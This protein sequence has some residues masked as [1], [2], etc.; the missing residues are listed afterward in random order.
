MPEYKSSIARR[1]LKRTSGRRLAYASA[2]LFVVGLQYVRSVAGDGD[3]LMYYAPLGAFAIGWA[4]CEFVAYRL[5]VRSIKSRKA[6]QA[7]SERLSI[8]KEP[9]EATFVV[10]Q[11]VGNA[12]FKVFAAAALRK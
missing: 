3:Y 7:P 11:K 6:R 4:V 2:L 1:I 5:A 10:N 12:G 8:F 9:G